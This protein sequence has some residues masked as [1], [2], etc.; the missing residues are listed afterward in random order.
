MAV[1]WEVSLRN[2][3]VYILSH[4]LGLRRFDLGEYK[5]PKDG[6]F[7]YSAVLKAHFTKK[8]IAPEIYAYIR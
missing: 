6:S 5:K 4:Y 2:H 3:G 1:T 7:K 8:N